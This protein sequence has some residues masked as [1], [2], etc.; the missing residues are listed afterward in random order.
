MAVA[1]FLKSPSEVPGFFISSSSFWVKFIIQNETDDPN[2]VIN[3]EHAT[4][5]DAVLYSQS[6]TSGSFDSIKLTETQ[7]FASRK[8]NYQTYMFDAQVSKGEQKVFF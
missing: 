7:P 2:L 1:S 4:I 5:D 8:Y 3:L 6:A